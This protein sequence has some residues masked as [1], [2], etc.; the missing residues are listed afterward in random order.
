MK[1]A[2]RKVSSFGHHDHLVLFTRDKTKFNSTFFSKAE[3]DFI[4]LEIKNEKKLIS[5]NQYNRWIFIA[6]IEK[7]GKE[8]YLINEESRKLGEKLVV[9]LKALLMESIVL[10][11]EGLHE[12]ILCFAEGMA[13]GNYQFLKYKK[14]KDH[15]ASRFAAVKIHSKKISDEE[16]RSLDIVVEAT[17]IARDLVNEPQSF[18][19]STQLAKEFQQLGKSAGFKTEVY[20]K[21]RIK[22]KQ[23]GGLLAVNQGSVEPPTFTIMEWKPKKAVNKNPVV[24]V[25]KAV[26]YDTGGLS[27][28][29]TANSMD[30]MKSDMAGGALVGC[31]LYALAKAEMPVHVI[32]LV[33]STDNRPGGNAYT[34]GDVITMY[35]GLTVEVLNTD[36]EGRLILADALHHAKE[37]NPELVL[38]FSTLTGAA[39][40]AVGA[41]G[42][43]C[44]GSVNDKVKTQLKKSGNNVFERLAEFPFWE[45]YD[46]LIKSDI[47][48]LKNIGGPVAGAITAGRF[49]NYFT[50]Y[51]YMHFDIAGPSF[52]KLADSYRGKNAT[53][54]G[55]RLMFDYFKSLVG[56]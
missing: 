33:P 47:A 13:L 39:A 32:G 40:V 37:Y 20:D 6:I 54:T 15:E 45:E 30:Y 23:M 50:D 36:A 29:P 16:I 28:K 31:V 27:L 42:I 55:V 56:K 44:M 51:P 18:L 2:I 21:A 41:Y 48:D 26:V 35:S 25:G 49:L 38:E 10:I 3:L 5:I 19:T 9:R 43:V 1:T 52:I 24:L 11:D 22:A 14:E 12:E 7:G 53:G 8:Q 4:R 17:C 46:E 34:P